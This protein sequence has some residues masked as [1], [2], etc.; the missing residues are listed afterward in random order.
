MYFIT[1]LND[2][3]R[4]LYGAYPYIHDVVVAIIRCK[5]KGLNTLTP[6]NDVTTLW[7]CPNCNCAE[8]DGIQNIA[9]LIDSGQCNFCGKFSCSIDALYIDFDQG[10][11]IANDLFNG[12]R[13]IGTI[14]VNNESP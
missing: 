12:L 6:L 2:K 8:K 7:I 5:Y 4:E 3:Y 11:L 9:S 1:N 14:K 13:I 10:V